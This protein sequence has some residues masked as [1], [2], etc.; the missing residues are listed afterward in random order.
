MD[1]IIFGKIVIPRDTEGKTLLILQTIAVINY[2][3]SSRKN[4]PYFL[5]GNH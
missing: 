2:F 1:Y 4:L 5:S 3:D